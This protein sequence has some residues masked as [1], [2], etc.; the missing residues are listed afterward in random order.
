MGPCDIYAAANVPCVAAY[1]SVRRLL[2]TYTGALYQVRKG[3]TSAT[4]G[5]GSNM[6][7]GIRSGG[8]TMDIPQTNGFAD[9][10][11]QDAFCGSDPCTFSMIY[12]Q[13]GKANHLKV[14]PAGC[15]NDGSANLADFESSAKQKSLMVGGHKV[16][17]L[18][19]NTREGYRNNATTGVPMGNT[20]Q[21]IYILA[22]G[23]HGRD[24]LGEVSAHQR[25]DL[26]LLQ[27]LTG[28]SGVT[29]RGRE[30]QHAPLESR[31]VSHGGRLRPASYPGPRAPPPSRRTSA[32]R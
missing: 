16:Y 18:Y 22:D 17:A 1:S 15:Y 14:A 2:S 19:T 21:G 20:S 11:M 4:D 25:R 5:T 8:T 10:A 6:K 26:R 30:H 31:G 13:S 12:D 32:R 3:G 28:K 23:T 27:H 9:S 7:T 24:Q 29:S